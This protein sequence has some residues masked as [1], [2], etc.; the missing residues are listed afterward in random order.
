[1]DAG[2][3][4]NSSQAQGSKSHK[5]AKNSRFLVKSKTSIGLPPFSDQTAP[6]RD[7]MVKP[8]LVLP[9]PNMYTVNLSGAGGDT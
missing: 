6:H 9:V 1:M 3:I 5:A 2:V 8:K 4:G 7:I